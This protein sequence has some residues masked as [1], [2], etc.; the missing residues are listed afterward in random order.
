MSVFRTEDHLNEKQIH[1][2]LRNDRR[3][4]VLKQLQQSVGQ[5]SVRE[6]SEAIAEAETGKSPPPRNIRDSVY[7]ALN[8]THLPKL[9]SLGILEYNQHRKTVSLQS[10][11]REVSLYMEVI[12]KYGITWAEY[13]QLLM[14]VSLL[15][16][17]AA[18]ISV[19]VI[20]SVPTLLLCSLFL[21]VLGV[22]I[23]NQLWSRRWVYLHQLFS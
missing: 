2:V 10:S 14:L 12:T 20:S 22:S 9:D 5:L 1:N 7:N 3:R 21:V 19:P 16:I 18:E 6:L 23:V 4:Q 13:Y 8:Q 15:A 17:L 11:A